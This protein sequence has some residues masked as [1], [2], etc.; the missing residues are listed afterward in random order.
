ME[1]ER[2]GHAF[3]SLHT[4]VA[5]SNP[6]RNIPQVC[7][8]LSSLHSLT[9]SSTQLSDWSSVESLACLRD[10]Y[11]LRMCGVPLGQEMCERERR[12]SVIARIPALRWLN[13]SE[14][15]LTERENAERWLIRHYRDKLERPKIYQTLV[16]THGLLQPLLDL[17]LSPNHQVSIQFLIDHED[18]KKTEVESVDIRQTIGDLKQTWSKRL[19]VPVSKL[20][21]FYM[22]M[23]VESPHEITG[24]SR[25]LLVFKMKDGDRIHVQLL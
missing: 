12:F 18:W 24:N 8:A 2:L 21:I 6:L 13:K 19:N 15:S 1:L 22:D 14:I 20:R 16:D 17:S 25:R 11:D 3:P 10:L 5:I 4:L 9:L 7:E 23:E